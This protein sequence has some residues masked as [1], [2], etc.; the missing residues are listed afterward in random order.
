MAIMLPEYDRNDYYEDD[1]VPLVDAVTVC[2]V[3]FSTNENYSVR[4]ASLATLEIY[5][6]MM[7]ILSYVSMEPSSPTRMK[8]L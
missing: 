3:F 2:S 1:I 4:N 7:I 8:H 6:K 5:D